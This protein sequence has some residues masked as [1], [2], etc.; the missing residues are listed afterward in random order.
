MTKELHVNLG[1]N[2]SCF[3]L[4]SEKWYG[5]DRETISR[6]LAI[7][8]VT[9]IQI[10]GYK[11]DPLFFT[12][13]LESLPQSVEAVDISG[14]GLQGDVVHAASILA[15]NIYVRTVSV[16]DNWLGKN[17]GIDAA[18]I[19]TKSTSLRF[20]NLGHN[21]FKGND[22]E[23][24]LSEWGPESGHSNEAEYYQALKEISLSENSIVASDGS[25]LELGILGLISEFADSSV[26]VLI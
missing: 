1:N 25:R 23:K 13:L 2:V 24:V 21:A 8:G 6:L 4:G 7:N 20:I 9:K 5:F 22:K 19:F 10:T 26:E 18:K 15:K 16:A 3:T 17:G 14:N 11:K 12:S